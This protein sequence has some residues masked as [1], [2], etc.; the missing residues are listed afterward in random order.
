VSTAE[1]DDLEGELSTVTDEEWRAA[2]DRLAADLDEADP[3]EAAVH[4][5]GQMAYE[6]SPDGDR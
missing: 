3:P 2:H 1:P 6:W 4:L 5:R